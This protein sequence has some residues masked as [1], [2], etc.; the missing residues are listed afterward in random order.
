[1]A[2]NGTD[3]T[4]VGS[5]AV[6]A[7]AVIGA[8]VAYVKKRFP[9]A[10]QA[11]EQEVAKKLPHAVIVGFEDAVK[12]VEN[13]AESPFFAGKVAA[14]ELKAKHV[15]DELTQTKAVSEAKT[16]LLGIGKKYNELTDQE[17]VKA[18]VQLRLV[19]SSLGINMTDAQVQGI[20]TD[21]Q[22]AIESLQ[23]TA[24]FK[25]SFENTSVSPQPVAAQ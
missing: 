14:G 18:E 21:A 15:L 9:K 3:W 7:L 5:N 25:A 24:I 22:K 19:L 13:I 1:M 11:V 4:V 12:V 23:A 8:I 20:F 6:G 17:K 2:F 16:V 10:A